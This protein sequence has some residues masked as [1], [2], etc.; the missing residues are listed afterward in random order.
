M[1]STGREDPHRLIQELCAEPWKY[2]FFQALRAV[3]C[4]FP[5]Q[6]RLGRSRTLRDDPL[7]FSQLLSLSFATSTL[8][9][10]HQREATNRLAVQFMGL[11]GPNGPMPLR[12]TEFI[13][14][15]LRGIYDPDVRGTAA[16]TTA[17][18]GTGAPKDST[19]AEFLDI[20]HHRMISLFYRAWAVAQKTAD[21]DREEDRCFAEWLACLFGAGS[22]AMDGA[23]S[24]PTW[25]KLPF[26]GHLACQTRHSGGLEGVLAEAFSTQAKVHNLTGHWI[27][28]PPEQ[29]CYLGRSPSFGSL[30]S[31]CVVGSRIWDRQMKFTVQLGPM[32]LTQMENFLPGRACHQP[33]HDWIAFYT[34]REFYWEA[35]LLLKKE[36]VPKISLGQSGRLGY[37]MWLSS[38]PFKHDPGDYRVRGGGLTPEENS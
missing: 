28:I 23:D 16:D 21:F 14:N 5:E 12:L 3:E 19:L 31:T 24:V 26:T 32:S 25:Q 4:A 22:P 7:R 2:D 33:L 10:P 13:R 6:P 9:Q 36:E 17:E 27:T 20:F 15:R 18:S 38:Q 29:R 30:G 1:A 8:A 34:R 11:T 35:I 37:T